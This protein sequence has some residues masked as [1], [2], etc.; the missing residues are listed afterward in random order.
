MEAVRQTPPCQRPYVVS[1]A[2]AKQGKE[3]SRGQGR[4]SM[5]LVLSCSMDKVASPSLVHRTRKALFLPEF[6]CLRSKGFP[7]YV[8]K[9]E[10]YPAYEVKK[11]NFSFLLAEQH[12][13]FVKQL[14]FCRTVE[15][16]SL[17]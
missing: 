16:K 6:F 15:V 17:Q 2:L 12:E 1:R 11:K 5:S 7:P 14:S 8:V 10:V 3:V 4:V 9:M 13:G